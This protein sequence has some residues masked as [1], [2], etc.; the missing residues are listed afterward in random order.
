MGS[1]TKGH[2]YDELYTMLKPKDL[3]TENSSIFLI[4]DEI[5]FEI[6]NSHF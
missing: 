4:I 2:Q 5:V 6:N 3:E 1:A